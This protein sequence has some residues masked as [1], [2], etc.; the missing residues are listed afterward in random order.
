M[1]DN[2]LAEVLGQPVAG[3]VRLAVVHQRTREFRLW[4][5][6]ELLLKALA[7]I[8][9]IPLW[10]ILLFSALSLEG[11]GGG[12]SGGGSSTKNKR[13]SYGR[14]SLF[15]Y[16]H[17]LVV[18]LIGADGSTLAERT[19]RA[20]SEAHAEQLVASVLAFAERARLVV[21]ESI[22][23]NPGRAGPVESAQIW[24]GGRALMSGPGLRSAAS[25]EPELV[26]AGF[27]F[28]RN[29]G[30]IVVRRSFAP[31]S[32]WVPVVLAAIVAAAIVV[33]GIVGTPLSLILGAPFLV[34][35]MWVARREI[36]EGLFE[37]LCGLLRLHERFEVRLTP[38]SVAYR[39]RNGW[40][41]A[42]GSTEGANLVA[43]GFSGGLGA[44]PMIDR[45]APRVRVVG[46]EQSVSLPAKLTAGVG[47]MFAE[48]L[49]STIIDLRAAHG[50]HDFRSKCAYCGT[51]YD[52]DDHDA[53]P[54]CG[55][56]A[57]S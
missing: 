48:W 8:I 7:F 41:S 53:C 34:F 56:T 12:D 6:F 3:V 22:D 9:L 57:L 21:S 43:V 44:P 10:I 15:S 42:A 39:F 31:M 19:A 54:K 47:P 50:E 18:R 11:G 14:S 52:L 46:R 24:F 32:F 20:E 23:V 40:R 4:G 51:L 28:E 27:Q 55:A 5:L 17:E 30:E 38:G 26:Q 36:G 33:I 29:K 16:H 45:R 13:D 35:A 37:L 1:S 2:P 49:A 25:L